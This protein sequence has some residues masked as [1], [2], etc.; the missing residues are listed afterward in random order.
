MA[1][2]RECE[3]QQWWS[4]S[5]IADELFIQM[6]E[7]GPFVLDPRNPAKTVSV[8][9]LEAAKYVRRIAVGDFSDPKTEKPVFKVY[10]KNLSPELLGHIKK[11]RP[12]L[13]LIVREACF[14]LFR[15]RHK[16]AFYEHIE[17][18]ESKFKWR[19]FNE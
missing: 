11:S 5:A 8:H 15:A 3:N 19:L 18:R 10:T 9:Y 4:S 1:L 13:N 7:N 6:C 14:K 16:L 2:E 17:P 12:S